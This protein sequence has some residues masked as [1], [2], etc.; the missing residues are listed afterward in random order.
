MPASI[1]T[2]MSIDGVD[3]PLTGEIFQEPSNRS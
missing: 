1:N 3:D 2:R